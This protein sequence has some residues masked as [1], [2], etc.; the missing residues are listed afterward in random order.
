MSG[1]TANWTRVFPPGTRLDEAKLKL[2]Q[3][4]Q[5]YI[6]NESEWLATQLKPG[7]LCWY[8]R[9]NT[10]TWHQAVFK[11]SHFYEGIVVRLY[12]VDPDD[13]IVHSLFLDCG[14]ELRHTQ[15]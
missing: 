8:R 7:D 3:F 11:G 10:D 15:P 9:R 13:Y 1:I 14:D 12:D 6:C 4:E 5:A 2:G